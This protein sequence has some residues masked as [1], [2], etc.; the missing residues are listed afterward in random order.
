MFPIKS[1]DWVE[2]V[3][4]RSLTLPARYFYDDEIFKA[5]RERIFYPAWHCVGHVNELA[6]PGQF[7]TFDIFDQSIVAV[8]GD[9]GVIRSFHNVCQHRGT[10]MLDERRGQLGSVIGCGYHSLGYCHDGQLANASGEDR[11]PGVDRRV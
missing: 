5:E 4:E 8:R 1:I 7:L 6:E 3:P 9:D 10:R 11:V 2:T